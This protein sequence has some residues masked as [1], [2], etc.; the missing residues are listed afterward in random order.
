MSVVC[1]IMRKKRKDEGITR[2]NVSVMTR[3]EGSEIAMGVIKI[4]ITR[5]RA[6]GQDGKH[7]FHVPV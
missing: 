5:P 3:R 4:V 1:V 6:A 7:E 2:M